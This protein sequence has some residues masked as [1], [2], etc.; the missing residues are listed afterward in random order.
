[1]RKLG[2]FLSL[3]LDGYYC[4]RNGDM[5]WAHRE[6]P[7]F[8]AFVAGNAA[9]GGELLM[10]RVTY[11][12]M[13]SYW[14]TPFAMEREPETAESMNSLPKVV[15]SR[16]L[17]A[18][19]WSNSRLVHGSLVEEVRSMKAG[20]GRDMV[21]LGSA[22]IVRQLAE[23]GLVDD[24]QFVVVPIALG[25]GRPVFEGLSRPLQ[26]ELTGIRAFRNGNV[27]LSYITSD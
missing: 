25:G 4:D 14:P 12:L 22:S 2:I 26:L 15:F 11:E 24:Y 17:K 21:V 16:T 6:D 19:G 18:A 20:K 8:K 27:L 23:A 13:A 5:S 9:S 1:M 10:G 3:S 7:E